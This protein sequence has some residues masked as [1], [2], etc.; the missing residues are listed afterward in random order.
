MDMYLSEEERVEALQRW[1]KQ[2]RNSI[3]TGLLIGLL[4]VTGWRYWQSH[5]QTERE[6]ASETFHRLTQSLAAKQPQE[7]S[8][9]AERLIEASGS[10]IYAD[11]A[12]LTLAKIKAD[13]GDLAAARLRLEEEVNQGRHPALK[14]VAR[15]RLARVLYALGEFDKG[16]QWLDGEMPADGELRALALEVRGDLLAGAGRVAEAR[17]AFLEAKSKGNRSPLL[18]LKLHDLPA[19]PR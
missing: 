14:A 12:R 18:D 8:R 10:T 9:F 2:N 5:Q 15:L 13:G 19:N 1:W 7:A 3:F 11:F 16:L 6:Q 4:L 17:T